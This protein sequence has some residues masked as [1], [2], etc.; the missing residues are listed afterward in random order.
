[1][2]DVDVRETKMLGE[3]PVIIV[4]VGSSLILAFVVSIYARVIIN[5]VAILSQF[6]TQEV[7]CIRDKVGSVAEGG[8]VMPTVNIFGRYVC[9][10]V[11][12]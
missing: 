4:Q 5:S 9:L 1:M 6:Q 11:R 3:T 7:Y 8:Q 10:T 12:A 2:S